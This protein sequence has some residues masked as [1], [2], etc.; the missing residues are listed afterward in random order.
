V[1]WLGQKYSVQKH[2]KG[3]VKVERIVTETLSR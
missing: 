2:C 3:T 1:A